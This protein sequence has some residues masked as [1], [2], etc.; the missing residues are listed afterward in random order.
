MRTSAILRI[1]VAI[2]IFTAAVAISNASITK[3][4][5]AIVKCNFVVTN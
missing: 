1:I 5:D 3:Q 2:P 4:F